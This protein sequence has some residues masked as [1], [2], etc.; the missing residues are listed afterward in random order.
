VYTLL[1]AHD[2]LTVVH[3][4]SEHDFPDAIRQQAYALLERVLR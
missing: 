1:G 4:D 2:A 3:P